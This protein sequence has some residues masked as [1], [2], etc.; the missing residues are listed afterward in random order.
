MDKV[1]KTLWSHF[2]FVKMIIEYVYGLKHIYILPIK[3]YF[4]HI[5]F[6]NW[7]VF[8][9][10]Y[11][12]RR[13]SAV[14]HFVQALALD[15][16]LWSAYEELCMLGQYHEDMKLMSSQAT[17]TYVLIIYRHHFLLIHFVH[18]GFNLKLKSAWF[19]PNNP[20]ELFCFIV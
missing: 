16:L 7:H 12:D 2:S 18:M 20:D 19:Y 6:Q 8:T 9:I 3:E 4:G 14:D 11:T 15:P 10:R 5:S 13:T 17:K 1:R